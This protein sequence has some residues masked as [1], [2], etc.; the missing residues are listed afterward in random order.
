MAL[1]DFTYPELSFEALNTPADDWRILF[2]YMN[3]Q[4]LKTLFDAGAGNA[5]SAQVAQKEF[6]NIYVH[7]WEVMAKRLEGVDCPDHD[8]RVAD[9]FH[10]PIPKADVHFLYLPTGPL[11]ECILSQIETGLLIAAI[12]SHGELFQRLEESAELVDELPITATRHAPT[13]RI[14]RWHTGPKNMK[15]MLRQY[16]YQNNFKQVLI[17]DN[18]PFE[19]QCQWLADC[20]GLNVTPDDYVETLFPPRRLK[21]EQVVNVLEFNQYEI[22]KERRA[23][24]WRK[25]FIEPRLLVETPEGIRIELDGTKSTF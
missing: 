9:L 4:G 8:V 24:K 2:H 23:G 1:L 14:Y 18:D 17:Q 5:L 11:L 7:A 21:L 16:S 19:G 22:L 13:M 10:E 6:S 15:D 12:E 3:R 20:F 25:I